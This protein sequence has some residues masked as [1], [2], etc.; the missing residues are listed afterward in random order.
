MLVR[1]ILGAVAQ[2]DK[3]MTVAKLRGARERKRRTGVR[4]E[5]RKPIA[6]SHP[7][8]VAMA[9]QLRAQQPRTSLRD[10]SA[11]LAEAGIVTKPGKGK[12]RPGGQPEH[13]LVVLPLQRGTHP[14]GA[15]L[16]DAR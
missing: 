12:K 11:A 13:E 5:G 9:R 1:Q 16:R 15:V 8:A 14:T 2:F 6:E 10:I 4:V 7:E 3:A